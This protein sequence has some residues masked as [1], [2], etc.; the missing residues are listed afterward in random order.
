MPSPTFI[1]FIGLPQT[2][3]ERGFRLAAVYERHNGKSR[4]PST[5]ARAKRRSRS[6]MRR[7]F[8]PKRGQTPVRAAGPDRR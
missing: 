6:K 4:S 2:P 7:L 3:E 8:V 1:T 5:I